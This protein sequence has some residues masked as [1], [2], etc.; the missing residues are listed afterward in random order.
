MPESNIVMAKGNFV[1]FHEGNGR[2]VPVHDRA[3]AR[4]GHPIVEANPDKWAPITID[5]DVEQPKAAAKT[6]ERPTSSSRRTS[7]G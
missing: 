7:S 1:S 2:P 3:T 6:E 4:V 5:F